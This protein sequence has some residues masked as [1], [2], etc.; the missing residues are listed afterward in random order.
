MFLRPIPPPYDPIEWDQKP[1]GEKSR[2]VFLRRAVAFYLGHL[3]DHEV[4]AMV[5]PKATENT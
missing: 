1:I 4:A 2:M 3:G 5:E